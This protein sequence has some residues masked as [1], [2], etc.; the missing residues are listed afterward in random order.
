MD[1]EGEPF[2]DALATGARR[3]DVGLGTQV[4]SSTASKLKE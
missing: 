2:F 3:Y 1:D 4:A